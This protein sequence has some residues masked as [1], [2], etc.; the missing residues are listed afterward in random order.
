MLGK[1][2]EKIVLT[3]EEGS[4]S[5]IVFGVIVTEDN[6]F[7]TLKM[8]DGTNFIF[9]KTKIVSVRPF[10]VDSVTDESR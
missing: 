1:I 10:R 3:I 7:I 4:I 5:K 6:N 8:E 2:G 9:N